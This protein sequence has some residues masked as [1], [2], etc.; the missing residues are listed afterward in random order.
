M[1]RAHFRLDRRRWAHVRRVVLDRDRYRCQSCGVAGR[2]EVDHIIPLADGGARWDL[3]N[4]QTLCRSPCHFA[5]T[6][7][8]NRTRRPV[9]PAVERWRELVEELR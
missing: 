2:L 6:A 9:S 4:L 1:G 7:A 5:K 8:E 3:S